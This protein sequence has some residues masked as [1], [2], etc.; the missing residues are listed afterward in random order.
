MKCNYASAAIL[1]VVLCIS[2]SLL[3]VCPTMD[4]T[5][6]CQVDLADF[7][8]FAVQWLDVGTTQPDITWVTIND[9]GAGMKDE[10]G[11]PISMGGFVGQM[12]M[13]ET[14]NAEYCEFL[15]TLFAN[16]QIIVMNNYI[17]ASTDTSLTQYYYYLAGE[18]QTSDGAAD[19]G[20]AHINFYHARF[21]VDSGFE[22]YPV[23]YVTWFG[24]MAF[25]N[26][27]GWRLPT[28]WE[29]QAVADYN[30]T[31]NYGCGITINNTIAN[32][33]GS[34]HPY[35]ISSVRAFGSYGYEL[36]AMAGNVMEWTSSKYEPEQVFALDRVLR[37]GGWDHADSSC[38]VSY[39]WSHYD[40]I[41]RACDAGFRVCR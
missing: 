29:W 8:I 15:N 10:S 40:P 13:Y 19:G 16:D 27:Y 3:A 25:A 36:C 18:G 30:G 23:T 17:Y 34:N 7:A 20:A 1:A 6:D 38:K 37:G 26:Y 11:N 32:Y 35:G 2:G 5:G 22:R 39:R 4:F 41:F 21:S 33:L 14:T 31:Y 12:S 28:E 24:A 9:S